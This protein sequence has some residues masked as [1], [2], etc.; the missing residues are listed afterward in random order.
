MGRK[1]G[2]HYECVTKRKMKQHLGLIRAR[3]VLKERKSNQLATVSFPEHVRFYFRSAL[4]NQ[5]IACW[6]RAGFRISVLKKHLPV[7]T[8]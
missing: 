3:Q 6:I 5:L 1:K 4:E 2:T 7:R 8:N